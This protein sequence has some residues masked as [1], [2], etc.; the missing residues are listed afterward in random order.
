MFAAFA[1]AATV[2]AAEPVPAPLPEAPQLSLYTEH[3]P[4]LTYLSADSQKI[5]GL[6]FIIVDEMLKRANINYTIELLPWKRALS[7]TR[8]SPNTCLFAMDR[9]PDRENKFLWVSP[10]YEG[11]WAFFKRPDS[12]LE[13]ESLAD[14]APYQIA[15]VSGYASANALQETGHE[16]ILNAG[17]NVDAVRLLFHGRVDL[18]LTGAVEIP[19]IAKEANT[20]LPL[21]ALPFKNVSTSMGCSL[22]TDPDLMRNLQQINE[23]MTDFKRQV[24][25]QATPTD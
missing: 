13:L 17:T 2:T 1:F 10:L 22:D 3:N 23:E 6:V 19:Y 24:M 8:R 7:L 14:I 25:G 15:T 21:E 16:R 9:T 12:P 20:P 5:E 4:P 18:L 11:R